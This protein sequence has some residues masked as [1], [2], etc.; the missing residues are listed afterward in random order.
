MKEGWTYEQDM[1]TSVEGVGIAIKLHN[2][3]DFGYSVHE[4]DGLV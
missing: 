3:Q 2:E 4:G 1:G